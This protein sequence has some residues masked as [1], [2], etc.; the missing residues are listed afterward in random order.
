VPF[1]KVTKALDVLSKAEDVAMRAPELISGLH[2][3]TQFRVAPSPAPGS[4]Y[5]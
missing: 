2:R 4:C 3:L 1:G 5:I